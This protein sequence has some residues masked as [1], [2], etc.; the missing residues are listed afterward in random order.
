MT[1]KVQNKFFNMQWLK[2]TEEQLSFFRVWRVGKCVSTKIQ[3]GQL[4]VYI[5][6]LDMSLKFMYMYADQRVRTVCTW[7][8]FN[9]RTAFAVIKGSVWSSSFLSFQRKLLKNRELK[10]TKQSFRWW[11]W[12][13]E[14]GQHNTKIREI[15]IKPFS[16]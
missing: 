7:A 15:F 8:R 5:Q 14:S 13:G 2:F 3:I 1:N 11:G 9:V 12:R 6:S 4:R 10:K 16:L